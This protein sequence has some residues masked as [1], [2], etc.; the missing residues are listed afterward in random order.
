MGGADGLTDGRAEARGGTELLRDLW[1]C[2]KGFCVSIG[3]DL[4]WLII[5][6]F[7]VILKSFSQVMSRGRMREPGGRVRERRQAS[8]AGARG[9]SPGHGA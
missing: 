4:I 6:N 9:C 8:A 2:W 5:F 7:V 3:F 1:D